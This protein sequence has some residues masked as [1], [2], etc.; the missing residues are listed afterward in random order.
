ME[1]NQIDMGVQLPCISCARCVDICPMKL[2]PT[3]IASLVEFEIW[4]EVKKFGALDCIECGSCSYICPSKR[5]LLEYIK[6]GKAKL[7]EM[8]AKELARK[9]AAEE[10]LKAVSKA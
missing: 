10:E 7:T 4:D 3:K 1:E 8:R 5:K 6:F 2:V 9:R